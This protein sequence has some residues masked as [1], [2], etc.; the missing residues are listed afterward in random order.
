MYKV[1]IFS[2]QLFW[3][4]AVDKTDTRTTRK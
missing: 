3:S 4:V 2:L 1:L